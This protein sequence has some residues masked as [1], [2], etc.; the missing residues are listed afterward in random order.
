MARMK[1]T[2][3]ASDRVLKGGR[4]PPGEGEAVLVGI[5]D[6]A[7]LRLTSWTP[8]VICTILREPDA[9]AGECRPFEA[10]SRPPGAGIGWYNR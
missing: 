8:A 5:P 9:I 3:R 6:Q 4:N 2:S 1:G 7:Q 10:S